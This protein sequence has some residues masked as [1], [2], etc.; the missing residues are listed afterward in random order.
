[1]SR[2]PS[3]PYLKYSALGFQMLAALLVCGYLGYRLDAYLESDNSYFTLAGLLLG[4]ACSIYFA[5]K[6]FLQNKE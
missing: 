5:L 2:R 6:L 1:M 4:V 3:D